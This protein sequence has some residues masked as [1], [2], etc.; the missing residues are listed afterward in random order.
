MDG[1]ENFGVGCTV[2]PVV[3]L[4][5]EPPPQR[6]LEEIKAGIVQKLIDSGASRS[7]RPIR[8]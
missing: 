5:S 6:S 3:Q 8:L 4:A 1:A 2:Q 7:F